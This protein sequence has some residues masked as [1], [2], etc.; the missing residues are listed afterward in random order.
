MAEWNRAGESPRGGSGPRAGRG[1][2][3]PSGCLASL[4]CCSVARGPSPLV[5][6]RLAR[7]AS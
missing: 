7:R 6:R 3:V 4:L 2:L 1:R 5:R